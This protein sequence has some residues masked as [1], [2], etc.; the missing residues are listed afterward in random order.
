MSH[1]RFSTEKSQGV[2]TPHYSYLWV[3]RRLRRHRDVCKA[4]YAIHL[5]WFTFILTP[6]VAILESQ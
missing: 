6:H 4:I 2:A 1:L 3:H 5:L